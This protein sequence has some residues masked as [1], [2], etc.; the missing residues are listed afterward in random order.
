MAQGRA[1]PGSN[2]SSRYGKIRRKD[3]RSQLQDEVP[4]LLEE[5]RASSMVG[6]WQQG[7]WTRWEQVVEHKVAW[8]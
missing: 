7:A 3:M 6:M 5:V 1:D 2:T 8:A 4:A